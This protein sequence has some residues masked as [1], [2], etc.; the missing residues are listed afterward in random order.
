[1][2]SWHSFCP[3]TPSNQIDCDDDTSAC[4]QRGVIRDSEVQADVAPFETIALRLAAYDPRQGDLTRLEIDFRAENDGCSD[5][6]PIGL[7]TLQDSLFGATSDGSTGCLNSFP[8]LWYRF[9]APERGIYVFTT[10]GTHDLPGI[11]QGVDTVL[12]VHSGCPGDLQDLLTCND[13]SPP[14]SCRGADQGFGHDSKVELTLDRGPIVFVRVTSF[15]GVTEGDFL[16]KL[17]LRNALPD[18]PR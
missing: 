18:L 2:L 7:G 17:S 16:L 15:E 6:T 14:N 9:S 13:D 11:D 3:G 1:M 10:C 12:A 5:A 8:D 4:N